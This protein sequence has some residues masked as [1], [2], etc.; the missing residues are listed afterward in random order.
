M[1]LATRAHTF[2]I[3][4]GFVWL[5][6]A[7][8]FWGHVLWREESSRGEEEESGEL[9]ETRPA[10]SAPFQEV[11]T[12][13]HGHI[14]NWTR[15]YRCPC[16]QNVV[17]RPFTLP[18]KPP[19]CDPWPRRPWKVWVMA[20][21]SIKFRVTNRLALFCDVSDQNEKDEGEKNSPSN[22]PSL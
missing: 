4:Y 13:V 21:L 7:T 6:V 2:K 8:S 18:L 3:A 16:S 10:L 19:V 5:V 11:F 17:P 1:S 15:P 12:V 9:L 14:L 20:G 22:P